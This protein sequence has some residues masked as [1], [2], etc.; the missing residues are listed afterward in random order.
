MIRTLLA[1][2]LFTFSFNVNSQY[3]LAMSPTLTLPTNGCY[4]SSSELIRVTVVN[5]SGFMYSGTFTMTYELDGGPPVSAPPLTTTMLNSGTYIYTFPIGLNG[6]FSSCGI[7]T[8][9]VYVYDPNDINNTNDTVNFTVISDCAP[10]LG[11]LSGTQGDTVCAG[12]NGGNI[13]L[14]GYVGFPTEWLTSTNS[15]GS[16]NSF[17]VP[18][19]DDTLA[20]SNVATETVYKVVVA[21]PYGYCPSDT[22]GWFT[23]NMSPMSNA[24]VLPPDFDVCDN[25]N[26]GTIYTTGYNGSIIDWLQ[27]GDNGVSWSNML[28]TNDAINYLNLTDTTMYQVIAQSNFCPPDTSA[29]ITLTLIPG[30]IGGSVVGESIVCNQENDSSLQAVGFFGDTYAWWY[31]LDSGTT[32]LPT[33]DI[34]TVYAYSNLSAGTYYF[35]ME[36]TQ[37]NCQSSWSTPHIL[38]VLPLNLTITPDTTII[39]GESLQL[40]AGGGLN[41]F[42]FPD[43]FMNN[44]N[45]TNP[46]VTPDVNTTYNVEVTDINGCVDTLSVQITVAPDITDLIVPNLFTPNGDGYNDYWTI[47]NIDGFPS[48]EVSIFNIYGQVVFSNSPY[49]N[50]WGGTYNGGS[51]PDGTYYYILQLN[52]PLYPDPIQGEITITGR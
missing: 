51:L 5:V 31:S 34:D 43:D 10:T 4:K 15:G 52:D 50:D 3:N 8:L 36:V 40:S 16:W 12:A 35:S 26:S 48:N 13:E 39:E 22:T 21:S 24:G 38:T 42:W 14:N 41:Y 30:S 6:D 46:I 11:T 7:H 32:W 2:L 17:P 47:A 23:L 19:N 49:T 29:P 44:P 27:S 20:Y 45:V 18:G 25:G 28:I 37:G 9:K 33:T 1:L